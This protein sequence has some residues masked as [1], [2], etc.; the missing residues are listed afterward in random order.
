MFDNILEQEKVKTFFTTAINNNKLGHAYLFHGIAGVGKDAAAVEI[1]KA[2]N[3]LDTET[4]PCNTCISCTKI[5]K[6]EH[7]DI[8]LIIPAP[9]K[10]LKDKPEEVYAKK[11][12]KINNLY[13]KV[14]FEGNPVISIDTIRDIINSSIFKPYEG[15]KKVVII[16][17]AEKMAKA[18]SNSILKILEEPPQDFI[19]ILTTSDYGSIIPTIKSRCTSIKFSPLHTEIISDSLIKNF[20][21]SKED[22]ELISNLSGGSYTKAA[23][24]LQEGI[25]EKIEFA[26]KLLDFIISS[27][28]S[29]YLDFAEET[30]KKRNAEFVRDFLNIVLSWAKEAYYH[31]ITNK[32]Q[33]SSENTLFQKDI[34]K[35]LEHFDLSTLETL[36]QEIEKSIDLINKNVYI[37]LIIINLIIN[38]RKQIK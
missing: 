18:A 13:K 4:I 6:M 15:R 10:T 20:S 38:M 17:Q 16:S 21:V 14:C 7:P 9:L 32:P 35:I 36:T 2:L 11:L 5:N 30:S 23:E 33:V 22:A 29:L 8:E 28:S 34:R 26:Q 1:A 19:F 24:Y 31:S 3:C 25:E 12:E 27:E 37:Y